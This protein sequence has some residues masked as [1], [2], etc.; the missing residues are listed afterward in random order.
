MYLAIGDTFPYRMP[1]PGQEG[2][3]MHM[4]GALF[5]IMNYLTSPT[6]KECQ[7]WRNGRFVYGVFEEESVPVFLAGFSGGQ[8]IVECTINFLEEIE[9]RGKLCDFF[10][11]ES[12][13]LN[14]FMV[15][16]DNN[17]LCAIRN[18]IL[19]PAAGNLLRDICNRQIEHYQSSEEVKAKIYEIMNQYS[20]QE[21]FEKATLFHP[22]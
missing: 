9:R 21:L 13:L 19:G 18:L 12:D 7:A 1:N 5:F 14:M 2:C 3:V 20:T 4:D 6:Q 17:K 15:D 11:G 16:A 8:M 22:I 10:I